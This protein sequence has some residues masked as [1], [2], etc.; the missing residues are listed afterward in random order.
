MLL[1]EN[2]IGSP[3]FKVILHFRRSGNSELVL[4]ASENKLENRER[5]AELMHGL[6]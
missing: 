4:V 6:N 2:C 3:L 5:R 1:L